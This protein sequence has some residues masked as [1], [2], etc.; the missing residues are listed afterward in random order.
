MSG[1]VQNLIW[2]LVGAVVGYGLPRLYEEIKYRIT[3]ERQA[4]MLWGWAKGRTLNV[5]ITTDEESQDGLEDDAAESVFATEARAA[6]ELQSYI[7]SAGIESGVKVWSSASF[8][9]GKHDDEDILSIGGPVNNS[10]SDRILQELEN[11]LP[12]VINGHAIERV[13]TAGERSWEAELTKGEV[14][15]DYALVVRAPNPLGGSASVIVVAGSRTHGSLIGT[16]ALRIGHKNE[17]RKDGIRAQLES[18]LGGKLNDRFAFV[19]E[20]TVRG[21]DHTGKL[22]VVDAAYLLVP[23]RS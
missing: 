8:E 3:V 22:T 6:A 14:A 21:D 11:Q 5:V 20:G 2:T 1:S 16:R 19:V 10:Y 15:R 17:S 23:E 18:A 12:Y 7:N 9:T 4:R 13:G